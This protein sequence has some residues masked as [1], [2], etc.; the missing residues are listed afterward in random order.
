VLRPH[1]SIQKGDPP[2]GMIE[3][4]RSI[5]AAAPLKR[6]DLE[7][8]VGRERSCRQLAA[9]AGTLHLAPHCLGALRQR[10]PEP[11]SLPKSL[12]ARPLRVRCRSSNQYP[13]CSPLRGHSNCA[14]PVQSIDINCL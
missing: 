11:I 12:V 8:D 4:F 1:R 3:A 6:D 7:G 5:G 10:V 14:F 13:L 2:G 9:P